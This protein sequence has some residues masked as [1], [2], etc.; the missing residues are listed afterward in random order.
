[1]RITN[2]DN[3]IKVGEQE[4]RFLLQQLIRQFKFLN[5][6]QTPKSIILPQLEDIDGIPIY[7]EEV[8]DAVVSGEPN[9]G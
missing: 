7:F 8:K 6:N 3:S 5:G 4:W 2:F 1:M 9:T